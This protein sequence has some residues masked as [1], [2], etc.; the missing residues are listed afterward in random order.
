MKLKEYNKRKNN[1][2]LRQRKIINSLYFK[3]NFLKQY[4]KL[5]CFVL[6]NPNN[7]VT[8]SLYEF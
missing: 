4:N 5:S 3:K 8:K 2:N 7:L 1:M 6:N